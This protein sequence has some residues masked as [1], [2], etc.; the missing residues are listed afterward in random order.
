MRHAEPY[1]GQCVH[2]WRGDRKQTCEHCGARC[3]RDRQGKI[4]EYFAAPEYARPDAF[5]ARERARIRAAAPSD[6]AVGER[7][8]FAEAER[9]IETA[10]PSRR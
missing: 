2:E 7:E 3:V 5:R 9:R 4:S 10:R 6:Q 8:W 1:P